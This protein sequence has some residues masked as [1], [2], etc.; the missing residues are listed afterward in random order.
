[1]INQLPDLE[2]QDKRYNLRA[3]PE[4]PLTYNL[5]LIYPSWKPPGPAPKMLTADDIKEKLKKIGVFL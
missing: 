3:V 1:M 5:N 4:E 2:A